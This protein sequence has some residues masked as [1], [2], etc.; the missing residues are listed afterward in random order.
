MTAPV[1]PKV[2]I[3]KLE[4][5]RRQLRVAISLWFQDGDEVAIH[6]LA[7][8]AHQI[9]HDINQ[10]RGGAELLFNNLNFRE[11]YRGEVIKWFK[12][13]MNFF[14][15][16]DKDPE[17]VIDFDPKLTE[18]FIM[19]SLMGIELFGLRHD[20]TEGA[21][22]MWYGL[23]NPQYL[24][25]KGRRQS[26]EGLTVEQKKGFSDM[27]ARQFFEQYKLARERFSHIR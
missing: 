18:M 16:A 10:H 21:F 2:R 25:E 19:A 17:G 6:T 27:S 14:K 9:I 20:S 5:A 3:P 12:K 1:A 13:E 4:A 8:A 11:E 26:V 22:I 24:T 7:C 15:H 23:K